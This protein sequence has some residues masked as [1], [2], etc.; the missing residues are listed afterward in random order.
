MKRYLKIF[1]TENFSFCGI[2]FVQISKI[3]LVS[4]VCEAF[5]MAPFTLSQTL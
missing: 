3:T 4:V 5:E 1:V 2:Y